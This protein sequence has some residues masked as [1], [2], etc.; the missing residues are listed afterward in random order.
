LPWP[1]WCLTQNGS[2]GMSVQPWLSGS[3][4]PNALAAYG[5]SGVMKEEDWLNPAP[6]DQRT[7]FEGNSVLRGGQTP[8]IE[9]PVGSLSGNLTIA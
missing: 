7:L 6:I 9:A 8:R 2:F 4:K 3:A 5:L 1:S